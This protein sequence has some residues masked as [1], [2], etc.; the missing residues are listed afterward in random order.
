MPMDLLSYF[1]KLTHARQW[2]KN[3]ECTMCTSH[4]H[5][6]Y[7]RT[8]A[9]WCH[10]DMHTNCRHHDTRLIRSDWPGSSW[11]AKKLTVYFTK[12]NDD[13]VVLRELSLN[14]HTLCLKRKPLLLL[15]FIKSSV[16]G[17]SGKQIT[18][19]LLKKKFL[20]KFTCYKCSKCHKEPYNT[21]ISTC[22]WHT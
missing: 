19:Q 11:Q 4:T 3:K 1:A 16:E 7:L 18:S 9:W 21:P 8:Y 14:I 2:C 20:A 12:T 6:Q 15:L 5:I 17:G 13:L 10:V 22:K